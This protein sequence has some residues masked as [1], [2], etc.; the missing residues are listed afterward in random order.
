MLERLVIAAG[1]PKAGGVVSD[2]TAEF[3]TV[4][5][6]FERDD[7]PA[8]AGRLVTVD[9]AD[10]TAPF[11]DPG[12]LDARVDHAAARGAFG[13]RVVGLVP[14][15]DRA[16]IELLTRY[17]RHV[18]RRNAATATPLWDRV[19]SRHRALH[20][21]SLPLVRADYD[22]ALDAW[23]WLLRLDP[24]ASLAVQAAALFHD[25]ER[26]ESEA[27]ARVEHH[28]RSYDAFKDAHARRGAAIARALLAGAGVDAAT[29]ERV[30]FLVE[31]HEKPGDDAELSLLNEAD[32]LSFFSL[33]SPGFIDYYG[34]EHARMKVARSLGRLG[35]HAQ[36][37]VLGI[38]YR[39]D[40]RALV[41]LALGAGAPQPAT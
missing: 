40:V 17:Q 23:Q 2:I 30:A 5:V 10:W 32:A 1:G 39:P 29:V 31:R 41:L 7:G 36:S 28:A 35:P 37:R 26:L 16:C 8:P 22:H 25:V 21:L 38:R 14:R 20:D 12:A 18:G 15:V 19:L 9:L 27:V 34:P 33:N 6:V 3:P 4:E 24:G 13:L 11:A